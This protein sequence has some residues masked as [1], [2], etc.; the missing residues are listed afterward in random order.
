MALEIRHIGGTGRSLRWGEVAEI[1][2][3]PRK[4]LEAFRL[5]PSGLSGHPM[6]RLRRVFLGDKLF[7]NAL[8]YAVSTCPWTRAAARLGLVAAFR[9]AAGAVEAGLDADA[10]RAGRTSPEGARSVGARPDDAAPAPEDVLTRE[11][12]EG[13]RK[14]GSL[15]ADRIDR[16]LLSLWNEVPRGGTLHILAGGPDSTWVFTR[17]KS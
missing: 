3:F 6:A 16:I 4:R 15:V 10:E 8:L 9:V 2:A 17:R 7:A 11:V 13:F 1:L 14:S 12:R 5:L